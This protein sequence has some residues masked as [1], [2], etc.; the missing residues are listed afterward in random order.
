M[1]NKYIYVSLIGLFLNLGVFGQEKQLE[2][3]D[4]DFE[5]LAYIDARATYIKV[6]E[7]GYESQDVYQKIADSY[8]FNADLTS[9]VGWYEKLY[10]K[11][12]EGLD[13]EYLFRYSQS[14]KSIEDYDKS[15][16]IMQVFYKSSSKEEK[17]SELF[18]EERN[19]LD[20]IALQS[21]RFEIQNLTK[22]NSGGSDFGPSFYKDESIVFASSRGAV[23]SKIVHEW[24]ESSFLNLYSTDRVGQESFN[25]EGLDKLNRKVN[26]KLHESTVY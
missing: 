3:A 17:R 21:G 8:Y 4:K 5:K 9:A 11:Y 19:Y 26:S 10:T 6:V 22:I 24:N 18:D 16:E 15:D 23:A 2:R 20:L 12:S 13:P 14:L 25:V 7:N 1:K